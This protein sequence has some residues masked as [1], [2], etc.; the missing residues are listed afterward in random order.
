MRDVIN[1]LKHY[2]NYNIS[3]S[4][5]R[6]K[7]FD[8]IVATVE[9]AIAESNDTPT[10]KRTAYLKWAEESIAECINAKN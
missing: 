10:F 7:E 3:L 1:A 8:L 9:K 6:F 4:N 5:P 2:Q